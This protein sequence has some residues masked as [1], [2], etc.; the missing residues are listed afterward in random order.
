[1]CSLWAI[2]FNYRLKTSFLISQMNNDFAPL[3]TSNFFLNISA[4]TEL[5]STEMLGS[6]KLDW[7]EYKKIR[8]VTP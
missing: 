2:V 3:P 1:M 6:Q 5:R 8:G 4:H 7:R